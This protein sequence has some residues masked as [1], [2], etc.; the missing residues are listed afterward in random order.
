[1]A[2]A[3]VSELNRARRPVKKLEYPKQTSVAFFLAASADWL[4]I[5][6]KARINDL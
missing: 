6:R 5:A 1:M 2:F 3:R 4:F